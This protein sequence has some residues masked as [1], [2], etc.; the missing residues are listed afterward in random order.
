MKTPG[1]D[2]AIFLTSCMSDCC[3]TAVISEYLVTKKLQQIGAITA[4]SHR[5]SDPLQVVRSN[6]ARAVGDFFRTR[7]HQS[8]SLFDSLDVQSCVHQRFVRPRIQPRYAT[9]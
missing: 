9:A 7:Y 4:V 2:V 5:I 3:E 1:R 8:L 6:V